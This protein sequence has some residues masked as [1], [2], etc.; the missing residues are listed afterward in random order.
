MGNIDI[1]LRTCE[2]TFSVGERALTGLEAN[3][4]SATGMIAGAS[5][6]GAAGSIIESISKLVCTIDPNEIMKVGGGA[7]CTFETGQ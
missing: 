1:T 3:E 2:L 5:S 4:V 6:E 7:E